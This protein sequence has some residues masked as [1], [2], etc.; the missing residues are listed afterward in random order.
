[1]RDQRPLPELEPSRLRIAREP[2]RILSTHVELRGARASLRFQ[3]G[4]THGGGRGT[5]EKRSNKRE[6]ERH[7]ARAGLQ[8]PAR[9]LNWQTQA[10][11]EEE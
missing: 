8:S 3:T 10:R 11:E 5:E 4:I 7:A 2:L 1:M 9:W 6:G